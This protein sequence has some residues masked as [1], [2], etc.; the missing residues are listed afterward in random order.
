MHMML[1]C[2]FVNFLHGILYMCVRARARARV[3]SNFV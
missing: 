2:V 3:L 1:V